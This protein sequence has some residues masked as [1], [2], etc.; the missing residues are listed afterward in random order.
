[1][2][3]VNCSQICGPGERADAHDLTNEPNY[4]PMRPA[5]VESQILTPEPDQKASNKKSTPTPKVNLDLFAKKIVNLDK[6][7]SHTK[8]K[9]GFKKWRGA[10]E[11][12]KLVDGNFD[13]K[14]KRYG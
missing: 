11:S 9:K 8:T 13:D 14:L 12:G 10:I 5:M 3:N 6:K 1:M 2:G 7:F 4:T